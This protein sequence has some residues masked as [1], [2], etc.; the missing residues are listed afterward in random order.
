[1]NKIKIVSGKIK[2]SAIIQTFNVEINDVLHT[3][4]VSI[5]D[6]KIESF[7][8]TGNHTQLALS[9]EC[10]EDVKGL[11]SRLINFQST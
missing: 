5:I 3:V 9:F 10:W 1:M 4:D 8:R 2:R 6:N 11:L 7:Y